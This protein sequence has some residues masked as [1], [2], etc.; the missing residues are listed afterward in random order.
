[1][2]DISDENS[3]NK[4][5]WEKADLDK[6]SHFNKGIRQDYCGS[7]VMDEGTVEQGWKHRKG[8]HNVFKSR[9]PVNEVTIQF[10]NF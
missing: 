6:P 8:V 4:D 10:M 5:V 1:M 9:F 2:N 7:I 3:N